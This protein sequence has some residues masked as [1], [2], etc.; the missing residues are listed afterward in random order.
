MHTVQRLVPYEPARSFMESIFTKLQD[1]VYSINVFLGEERISNGS[2]YAFLPTGQLI[3][4]AHVVTGRFPIRQDDVNDPEVKILAKV[5][6]RPEI[7][8]RPQLCGITIVS[9]FFA[10]P[11]QLDFAILD[12]VEP[13]SIS[14][15]LNASIHPPKLGETVYLAGFSDEVELPFSFERLIR[16]DV[17]GM[18]AFRAAMS[19]G[20]ESDMM[21]L[22]FKSGMV[23]NIRT[24]TFSDSNSGA[25]VKSDIFYID[26][27][28]HAGA[29]GGP[30]INRAGDAVG[31]ITQRAI[32]P[33]SYKESPGLSVPS[34][35]TVCL[36]LQPLLAMM[37]PNNYA[38]S[39]PDAANRAGF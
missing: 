2:G 18:D 39:A 16:P 17:P 36:S 25:N 15:Y 22:M 23:G 13:I 8:Y 6:G 12:P 21:T 27:G 26:N 38:P 4:A 9:D 14:S 37:Q 1:S 35:S 7:L 30:V 29:S 10:E 11:I 3:T 33:V 19:M 20:Y 32:T 31:L 28:I 24:V 34:G 5:R